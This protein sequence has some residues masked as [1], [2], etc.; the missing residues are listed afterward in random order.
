LPR[1]RRD[2]A[3]LWEGVIEIFTDQGGLDDRLA[4]MNERRNNALWIELQIFRIVL[5]GLKQ[6]DLN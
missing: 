5:L 6:I 4:I 1:I 3:R 2:K